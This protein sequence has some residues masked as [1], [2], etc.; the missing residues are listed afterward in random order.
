LAA[1][2]ATV[3]GLVQDYAGARSLDVQ[4]KLFGGNA[5]AFFGLSGS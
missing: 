2:Y 4:A 3:V 5:A 1:D